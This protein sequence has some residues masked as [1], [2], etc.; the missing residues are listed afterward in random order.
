MGLFFILLTFL[1]LFYNFYNFNEKYLPII[2]MQN[3][4]FQTFFFFLFLMSLFCTASILPCGRYYYEPEGGY[5]G[6]TWVKF[7]YQYIYLYLFWL[8]HYLDQLE[9]WFYQLIKKLFF[10]FFFFLIQ[11]FFKTKNSLGNLKKLWLS[12]AFIKPSQLLFSNRTF[13]F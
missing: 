13:F 10:F 5:V 6:N 11:F 3:S 7:S 12:D 4:I 8:L 1:P 2:A 9:H